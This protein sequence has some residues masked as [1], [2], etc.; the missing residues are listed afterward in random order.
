MGERGSSRARSFELTVHGTHA[1]YGIV[2]R[3]LFL[4]VACLAQLARQLPTS[5]PELWERE[6]LTW[7]AA[8]AARS[9][10]RR[11]ARMSHIE[12]LHALSSREWLA[13]HSSLGSSQS[14]CLNCGKGS[15][16]RRGLARLSM[17]CK[18]RTLHVELD[19][20]LPTS[21]LSITAQASYSDIPSAPRVVVHL[22]NAE[23]ATTELAS[24][25]DSPPSC[26]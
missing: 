4:R 9:N 10:K 21:G 16:S 25:I 13:L 8:P 20:P 5:A 19:H 18:A 3:T 14:V 23:H 11:K 2:P 15:V 1:A 7:I 17:Q 24:Q 22:P 26:G 12:S 6:L